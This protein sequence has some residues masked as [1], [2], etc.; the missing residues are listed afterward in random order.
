MRYFIGLDNGGTATKAA[1]FDE[2]GKE[3][4]TCSVST[5]ALTPKVGF[6]ER[7]MEDMWEANC[8]VV[9]GVLAKTGVKAEDVAGLGI[10]GHGKGLYLWGR[11]DMP[12]R[13][14]IISTDNRA[15]RYPAM[16]REDGTEEKAFACSLQH[17]LAC[18]PTALLAW[19]RDNEP[20]NY[21]NIRYVFECKDYVRFRL[22]GEARAEITDYSGSGLM[23]LK[24]RSF[25]RELLKIFGLEDIYGALPPLVEATEIAGYVTEEAAASCGLKEGTPVIGGM[26][27]INACAIGAGV[28]DPDKICMIAGTWSINEYIRKSPVEDGRVQMNSCFALPGYYL[29]EESSPTS[30][31]NL[32]WF[33]NTFLPELK[34]KLKTKGG[35]IYDEIDEWVEELPADTFVPIFLP[36]AMAS[37]VHP[38]ARASFVGANVSHTRKHLARSVFEGIAFCH[39]MHFERLMKTR[40]E[41]PKVIRL[42]GGAARAAVWAQMFADVMKVPVETVEAHETGALGVSIGAAVATGVY[43]TL[44]DAID[45]MTVISGRY[46]P[47]PEAAKA[48]DSKY[49]L[50]V[51][52]IEGLDGVWDDMQKYIEKR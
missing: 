36:F 43:P 46:E 18:Q 32:E 1:L 47:D 48:Y 10:S 13:N 16:W 39:R 44:D 50:Y 29:I 38:N 24:T 41:P 7:N 34:T 15:Y 26:F 20:T 9:R 27:D 33:I 22:T 51:K 52:V 5:D 14:G 28:T 17:T 8:S 19:I 30:A 25:D 31:G 49:A 35:S 23:N 12:V 6:V 4:G 42:A 40:E 2:H 21:S 3:I 11:D 37:N 45:N